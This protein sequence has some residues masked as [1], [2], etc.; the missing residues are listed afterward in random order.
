VAVT[1]SSGP[2][3]ASAQAAKSL[4]LAGPTSARSAGLSPA[5]PM[6]S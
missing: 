6:T 1:T 2:A 4:A 3:W 5:R